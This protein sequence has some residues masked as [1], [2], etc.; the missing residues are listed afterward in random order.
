MKI[1]VSWLERI[2][3]LEATVKNLEVYKNLEMFYSVKY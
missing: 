1:S 3:V 2:K